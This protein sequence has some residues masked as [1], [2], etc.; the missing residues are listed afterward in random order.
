M[1][2]TR[3]LTLLES[4][5]CGWVFWQSWL[6]VQ[7]QVGPRVTR[8]TARAFISGLPAV[9]SP[10][11]PVGDIEVTVPRHNAQRIG[12]KLQAEVEATARSQGKRV[13]ASQ[14]DYD[15]TLAQAIVR[16]EDNDRGIFVLT[17][18]GLTGKRFGLEFITNDSPCRA[19]ST[20]G[21]W[22]TAVSQFNLYSWSSWMAPIHMAKYAQCNVSY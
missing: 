1:V 19:W 10:S 18:V 15:N 20:V 8:G 3:A 6:V 22:H 14:P 9:M 16:V 11:Q 17:T 12:A 4:G 21:C 5:C 2:L 13:D 7:V